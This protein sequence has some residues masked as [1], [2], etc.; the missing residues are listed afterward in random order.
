MKI[1]KISFLWN[2]DFIFF[3]QMIKKTISDWTSCFTAAFKK[4]L[5]YVNQ[6][7]KRRIFHAYQKLERNMHEENDNEFEKCLRFGCYDAIVGYDG[8]ING[9][10]KVGA[11]M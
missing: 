1:S 4:Y 11:V 9:V 10:F 2:V 6:R 3:A 7:K 5:N 8:C